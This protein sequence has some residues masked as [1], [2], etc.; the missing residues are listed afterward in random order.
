MTQV[1]HRNN[2][3]HKQ[4]IGY[5]PVKEGRDVG[6]RGLQGDTKLTRIAKVHPEWDHASDCYSAATLSF[7]TPLPWN[8]CISYAL[9]SILS[10]RLTNYLRYVIRLGQIEPMTSQD[11]QMAIHVDHPLLGCHP[12]QLACIARIRFKIHGEIRVETVEW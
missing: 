8:S 12:C 6:R 1:Q 3:R 10:I 2:G 5:W 9:I 4:R 7:A 11:P